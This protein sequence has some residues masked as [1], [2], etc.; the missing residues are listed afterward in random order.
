MADSEFDID[1]FDDPVVLYETSSWTQKFRSFINRS[2][3]NIKKWYYTGAFDTGIELQQWNDI[4]DES[5][6]S[7][8]PIVYRNKGHGVWRWVSLV[9]LI[10]CII[11]MSLLIKN[12]V[13]RKHVFSS[14]DTSDNIGTKSSRRTLI[15][16]LDGFHPAYISEERTPFL[17]E[18]YIGTMNDTISTPYMIPSLP[19]QTFP[20]HW[21]MVTGK[22]PYG[23]GILANRFWDP[24]MDLQFT[25]ADTSSTMNTFWNQSYPLWYYTNE[26]GLKTHI[27]MWPGSEQVFEDELRN[28]TYVD[29]FDVNEPLDKKLQK[30]INVLEEESDVSLMFAYVPV[31]DTEGHKNGNLLDSGKVQV[32]K[33]V[34]NFISDIF[35]TLKEQDINIVVVSDHG[36][37]TI[38][39]QNVFI[40]EDLFGD[41]LS[42]IIK[43]FDDTNTLIY[44]EL[45]KTDEIYQRLKPNVPQ[46]CK[47]SHSFDLFPYSGH[48]TVERRIAPLWIVCEPGYLIVTA[49]K[50][51]DLPEKFGTHGFFNTQHPDTKALFLGKGPFFYNLRQK[52]N[53]HFIEPFLNIEIFSLLLNLLGIKDSDTPIHSDANLNFWEHPVPLGKYSENSK[54][55][56]QTYP[57]STY[58]SLWNSFSPLP[59]QDETDNNPSSSDNEDK[60]LDTNSGSDSGYETDHEQS[61]EIESESNTITHIIDNIESTVQDLIDSIWPLHP[62]TSPKNE[63]SST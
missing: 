14:T 42:G 24:K 19:S 39:K 53:D 59:S 28:P 6:D 40:W 33:D 45:A 25:I 2:K 27:H 62:D 20:N 41:D 16:S 43:L 55:M 11:L 26:H 23:H 31:V 63:H 37:T 3:S 61:H 57:E 49:A 35:H 7:D 29:A 36:M 54:L 46:Q 48:P 1:G 18:L 56:Y 13:D 47:L 38:L 10:A 15:I 4:A 9:L 44:T 8:I 58:N 30:I 51:K 32:L 21:S 60:E 34:D 12:A 50:Y 5:L 17:N 52:F 22:Y